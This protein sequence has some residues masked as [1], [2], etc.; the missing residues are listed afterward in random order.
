[1]RKSWLLFLPIAIVAMAGCGKIDTVVEEK[2]KENVPVF[3]AAAP[4]EY[5]SADTAVVLRI[6]DLNNTISFF[7]YELDKSYTLEYDSITKFCDKYGSAITV[8]QVTPGEIVDIRFLQSKKLLTDLSESSQCFIIPEVTG[9]SVDTASKVFKY[10]EDSYK[11]TDATVILANRKRITFME[12]DPKDS[13]TIS[14]MGMEIYSI[15][16]DKG[17]GFLSVKN[18]DPFLDGKL[19]INNEVTKITP[20]MELTL[21][22]GEYDVLVTKD[23]TVATRHIDIRANETTVLD[24]GDI[25][26]EEERTGKVLF[27]LSPSDATLYVDEH[28]VDPT[29]LL[30]FDYGVH[31]LIASA[32]GYESVS[33]YFNVGEELATLMLELERKEEEQKSGGDTS[34][35]NTIDG[36]YIF[37]SS[38]TGAEIFFDGYYVGK[39]SVSI[40]KKSGAHTITVEKSGYISKTYNVMID[41]A[42]KDVYYTFDEMAIQTPVVSGNSVSAN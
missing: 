7:N 23:K 3:E 13:V 8:S 14:G 37:I 24:L 41:N 6:S 38:M 9:F 42:P 39:T 35:D 11:I 1:M 30:V 20:N 33:K 22:E 28:L 19:E 34:E 29:N 10:K 5:D 17:H 40:P 25:E 4:G 18:E 31:H 21:K 2:Q 15:Q 26:V 12:I 32:E 16:I 27:V 36:S